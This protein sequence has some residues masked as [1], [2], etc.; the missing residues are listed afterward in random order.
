MPSASTLTILCSSGCILKYQHTLSAWD[1]AFKGLL[2]GLA[3]NF[4]LPQIS[5]LTSTSSTSAVRADREH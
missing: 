2:Q 5:Q 4:R 3:F 1:A